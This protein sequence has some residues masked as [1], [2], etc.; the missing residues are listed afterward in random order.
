MK[1]PLRQA[2][3]RKAGPCYFHP[4]I[5]KGRDQRGLGEQTPPL[6]GPPLFHLRTRPVQPAVDYLMEDVSWGGTETSV[7]SCRAGSARI[8]ELK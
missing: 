8:G 3:Y 7:R 2:N 6:P 1:L 4:S 5:K